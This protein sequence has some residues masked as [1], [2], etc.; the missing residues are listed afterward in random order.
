MPIDFA[1]IVAPYQEPMR[2]ACESI[3]LSFANL[4]KW[5]RAR[6]ALLDEAEFAS[7]IFPAIEFSDTAVSVWLDASQ[8]RKFTDEEAPQTFG[9]V[10][11]SGARHFVAGIKRFGS[12]VARIGV[13]VEEELIIPGLLS[14]F[15][16]ILEAVVG[17]MDRFKIPDKSMFE[18]THTASDLIGEGTLFFRAF[19][20]SRDE[21]TAFA[22]HVN[23][24]VITLKGDETATPG[25]DINWPVLFNEVVGWVV[26]AVLL[27]PIGSKLLASL[28]KDSLLAAKAM[29]LD[30]FQAIERQV[31]DLR[32]AVLDGI[33]KTLREFG[34]MAFF[35]ISAVQDIF[36]TNLRF[37]VAFGARYIWE[38]MNN[39]GVFMKEFAEYLNGYLSVVE[40]VRK[41]LEM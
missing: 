37:Y 29:L 20:E 36:I 30:K 35:F 1:N 26:G 14:T 3:A 34:D 19:F 32:R 27:V 6:V 33:Y 2:F 24:I 23:Q 41:Y 39:V 25:D 16:D 15:G 22:K 18:V 9:D 12:G 5:L 38:L 4:G 11:R 40:T 28:F 13:A 8:L 10:L 7:R 31:F 17:A 21:I